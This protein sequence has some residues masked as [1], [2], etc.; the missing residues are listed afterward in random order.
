MFLALRLWHLRLEVPLQ[1]HGDNMLALMTV[2]NMQTTGWF[3]TS[4]L[5]NAPLGQSLLAYPSSAGD[6]WNLVELKALS[7]WLSPAATVNVFYLIGFPLVA[8]TTYVCLRLSRVSLPVA[9]TI[10]AV[11]SWLPY[12]FLRG[13]SH[14]FLANYAAVPMLCLLVLAV[15]RTDRTTVFGRGRIIAGLAAAVLLGG[16]GLYY[17]GFFVTLLAAAGVLAS[18]AKRTWRPLFAALA[19]GTTTV[20]V[21]VASAWANISY[22]LAHGSSVDGRG[23]FQT[24]Y[25]GLKIT[26]LLMPVSDHRIGLLA[27]LR[28]SSAN[29]LIPGE[30]ME[31]LGII[32]AVGAVLVVF[33]ALMPRAA[34]RSGPLLDAWREIGALTVVA[35]LISTVAGLSAILAA[36]GFTFLRAWNRI[37]VVIA[38]LVL[39]GSALGLDALIGRASSTRPRWRPAVAWSLA[40]V[41]SVV[42]LLDQTTDA[43]IP[44]YQVMQALWH[45][46]SIFY[47]SVE[48]MLEPGTAVFQLPVAGFPESPAVN[49]LDPYDLLTGYLHTDT[50]SW[51]FGGVKGGDGEWQSAALTG[52]VTAALPAIVAT[53]FRAVLVDRRGYADHGAAIEQE[54]RDIVGDVP[55]V[56]DPGKAVIVFDIGAYAD[57]LTA[58]GDLPNRE[59]VLTTPHLTFGDGFYD[60]ESANGSTY[61][62]ATG[63]AHATIVNPGQQREVT[64][65]GSVTTIDA[66]AAVDLTIGDRLF[67]L[68]AVDGRLQIAVTAEVPS[69]VTAVTLTTDSA[70]TPSTAGD[71]RDLRQQVGDLR[72]TVG[73]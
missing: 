32:G 43:N 72:L 53:G 69:G 9:V 51:S 45:D 66:E 61:R 58:T 2:R 62:W 21:L 25:Y 11:Y 67:H 50:L 35:L 55:T 42:G 24:E 52:G 64:L 31:A 33:A 17:A 38:F 14:L 73:G 60:E 27:Q 20:A 6:L 8:V 54:I 47:T 16:T 56:V 26:N 22:I 57:R 48:Q 18:T 37:S 23:Y 19:L 10:G 65:T 70:P 44:Q 39:L 5:L 28:E 46:D 12:H 15:Y 4:D 1:Y 71:T 36:G 13:E 40:V 68:K 7:L 59:E 3:Q 29:T 34:H 63:E 49:T 41:V 30:G